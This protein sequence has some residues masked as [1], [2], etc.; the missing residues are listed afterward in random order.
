M[1]HVK[2]INHKIVNV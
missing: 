1:A 2:K